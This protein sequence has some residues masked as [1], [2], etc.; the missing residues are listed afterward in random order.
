MVKKNSDPLKTIYSGFKNYI[1]K[2]LHN[3]KE[4]ICYFQLTE[5]SLFL[6]SL[7]YFR[8]KTLPH[9]PRGGV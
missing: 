5:Q 1:R 9:N 8:Q 7:N 4:N 6:Q 2:H 3:V